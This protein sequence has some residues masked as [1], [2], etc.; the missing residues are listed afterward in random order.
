MRLKRPSNRS[1]ELAN[2]LVITEVVAKR[3][4]EQA[5]AQTPRG[6]AERLYQVLGFSA[7]PA[8]WSSGGVLAV[9][10]FDSFTGGLW[11]FLFGWC[12]VAPYLVL[13]GIDRVFRRPLSVR[14][15]R[16]SQLARELA[17]QRQA[18]IEEGQA[19]YSSPEWKLLRSQVI[20]E[21]GRTCSECGKFIRVDSD[22]TVDHKH[23]RSKHPPMSLERS[24]LRVVCRSCNARKGAD[25]WHE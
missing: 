17:K 11:L 5:E 15:E 24:N 4:R 14:R 8:F 19:F 22:V 21:E 1:V 7:L 9:F 16:V 6:L 13:E 25:E 2:G 3:L 20:E 23:P 18:R 10:L 12:L